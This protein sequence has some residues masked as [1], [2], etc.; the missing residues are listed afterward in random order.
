MLNRSWPAFTIVALVAVAFSASA[1]AQ[2]ASEF[3]KGRDIR[4]LISH[5]AG[6]GYDI[7]ARFF[8]KHLSSY[9]EGA[10]NVVPQNMPGAAGVIMAN[11]IASQQSND[12]TVIGLAPGSVA[13]APLIGGPGARYDA[14]K[15][16][17]IGSMNAEVGV[18]IAWHDAPVKTFADLLTTELVVGGAGVT[19]VSIVYPAVLK[20]VLGAKLKI[21]SGYGGSAGS[22]LAMER[23]ETQ[24]VGGWGYS[25]LKASKPDWLRDKKVNILVQLSSTRHRDLPNI[26]TVFDYAKTEEQKGTLQLV[27]ASSEMHRAIFGPPGIPDARLKALRAAFDKMM[28]DERVLAE[29]ERLNIEINNPMTG[30]RM[31]ELIEGL[32]RIEKPVLQAANEA[33][34]P[35]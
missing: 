17:W 21:I 16:S 34:S 8:A 4:I 35:K 32:Y 5:P 12:G 28:H 14:R 26:P 25:S 20:N 29:A 22:S 27:L 7:Y 23:G 13:T 9:L 19:D 18:S 31:A 24:G 6:G 10:P 33:M 15:L 1:Q 3:Y 30:P 2:T 11:S